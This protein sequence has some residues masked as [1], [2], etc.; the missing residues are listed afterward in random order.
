MAG[1]ET[2]SLRGAETLPAGGGEEFRREVRLPG[3]AGL[4]L[5]VNVRPTFANH[6]A[7]VKDISRR[8]IGLLVNAPIE[9][10][11][12]VALQV[13][14]GRPDAPHILQAQVVHCTPLKGGT[15]LVGCR[16]FRPLPPGDLAIF[17]G[18]EPPSR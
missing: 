14:D 13:G 1:L 4:T 3:R 9:V 18:D 17:R 7:G 12:R 2:A 16:F 15:W 5:K 8:G 11:S 10:G 6:R